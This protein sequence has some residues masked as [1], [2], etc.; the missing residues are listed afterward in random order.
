MLNAEEMKK[1]RIS[2]EQEW[3]NMKNSCLKNNYSDDSNSISIEENDTI[4]QR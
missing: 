4:K 2:I 1:V 3:L